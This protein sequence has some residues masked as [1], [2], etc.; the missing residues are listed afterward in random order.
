MLNTALNI[1]ALVWYGINKSA[2]ATTLCIKKDQP[3]NQCQGCCVLNEKLSL[4]KSESGTEQQ[5]PRVNVDQIYY[6]ASVQELLNAYILQTPKSPLINTTYFT[7]LLQ[8]EFF[9]PPR[10]A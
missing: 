3:Q 5:E 1:K 8:T 2:I 10:I 7:Q 4:N 6:L 9:H